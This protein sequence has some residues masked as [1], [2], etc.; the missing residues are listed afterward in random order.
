MVTGIERIPQV[1]AT[2]LYE[3][4]ALALKAFRCATFN[5]QKLMEGAPGES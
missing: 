2:S 5:K 1:T 3:E 4:A